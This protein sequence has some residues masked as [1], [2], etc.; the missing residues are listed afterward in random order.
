MAFFSAKI[1]SRRSRLSRTA[2][3]LTPT[4]FGFR[5]FR[6]SHLCGSRSS[7]SVG[8]FLACFATADR[9]PSRL[10]QP[11]P[12]DYDRVRVFQQPMKIMRFLAF[13]LFEHCQKRFFIRY[14]MSWSSA[15]LHVTGG[16]VFARQKGCTKKRFLGRLACSADQMCTL[17]SCTHIHSSFVPRSLFI[18]IDTTLGQDLM[19]HPL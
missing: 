12:I 17:T 18:C 6:L 19:Q 10:I 8:C 15:D 2:R 11:R 14:S 9:D 16:S 5:T 7:T 1:L 4:R 3:L 13:V